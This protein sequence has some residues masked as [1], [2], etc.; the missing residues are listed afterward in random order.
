[1]AT[2]KINGKNFAT[3][4]GTGA[5]TIHSD[6]VFPAGHVLKV[7]HDTTQES[8]TM[9]E[10]F[11][12]Y[13]E[14]SFTL[15]SSSSDLFFIFTYEAHTGGSNE[16]H[17]LKVYRNSSATVTTSHTLVHNVNPTNSSG[18]LPMT[19]Y[20][21]SGSAHYSSY[22]HHFKDSLSGFSVGDTLYY[23][24]FFRRRSNNNTVKI[25]PDEDQDGAFLTTITEVQK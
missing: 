19:G 15:T 11:V 10:S 14:L 8:N 18:T 24:F 9:T 3:Q 21:L 17:G 6:V 2:F 4:D 23:G 1:M 16:G 13:H 22:T 25:P 12:N 5:A 7:T 20:H